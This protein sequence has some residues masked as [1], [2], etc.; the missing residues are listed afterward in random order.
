MLLKPFDVERLSCSKF[1]KN[2]TVSDSHRI[3]A[4]N[5]VDINIAINR[6]MMTLCH[7][8]NRL[9]KSELIKSNLVFKLGKRVQKREFSSYVS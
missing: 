6:I 7:Q 3:T 9:I 1:Y 8:I 4:N 2:L 5:H